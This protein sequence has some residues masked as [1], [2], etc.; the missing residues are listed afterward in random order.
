MDGRLNGGIILCYV[1][2]VGCTCVVVMVSK[3]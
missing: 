3:W 1:M 2:G